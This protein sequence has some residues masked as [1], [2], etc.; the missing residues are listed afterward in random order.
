[1]SGCNEGGGGLGGGV[2]EGWWW[3][4]RWVRLFDLSLQDWGYYLTHVGV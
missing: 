2:G 1:M 4:L 3:L